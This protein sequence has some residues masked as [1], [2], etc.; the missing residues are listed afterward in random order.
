MT[1]NKS[2]LQDFIYTL[3]KYDLIESYEISEG[4]SFDVNI[5]L[6]RPPE[7]ITVNLEI[8]DED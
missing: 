8:S 6:K 1:D 2:L 3:Q 5:V 7:K 4:D